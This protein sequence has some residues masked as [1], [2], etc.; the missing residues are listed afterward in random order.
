MFIVALAFACLLMLDPFGIETASALRSE[1]A[2]LRITAP[3]YAGTD[4]VA[5]VL[6]DDAFLK[7]IGRSWPLGYAEQGR[8]LRNVMQAQPAGVFVDLL[9][10][11]AHGEAPA[12][13]AAGGE[14][15]TVRP[16]DDP[17]DLVRP[18]ERF[19][20]TP[21]VLAAQV[22]RD[23]N[24]DVTP[25]LCPE[26]PA[27]EREQLLDDESILPPLKQWV[28]QQPAARSIALVGWWGCGDRYPLILAGR[29]DGMSPAFALLRA[30]CASAP[31]GRAEC[32]GLA[33]ETGVV[34][35]FLRP[36]VVRWGA[37]P[38][39]A[40]RPFYAAGVCQEY[41]AADGSVP[42]ARR[43]WM[44]LEQLLLGVFE[45]LRNSDKPDL[46]L[47]CPSVN[48]IPAS[49]MW[50]GDA[51]AVR[52]LLAGRF[53]MVGAA[54]SGISDWHQSAVHGQ[55]P[56]VVLHAM[57]LDNL[58][59]LGTSYATEMSGRAS[60]RWPS[61][62]LLLLAYVVPRILL[63]HRERNSRAVAA[64]GL[65]GWIALAA[66]LAWSGAS[67]PAVFAAVAVG[68]ALDLIAPM[69]TFSYVLAIGLMGIGAST[70]LRFGVA[71]AN[72]VGMILVAFTFFHA[73][74]QF[75]KD[76]ERKGFP[77]RPL[78]WARRCALGSGDWSFTGFTG[79]IAKRSQP[80]SRRRSRRP[81]H[82]EMPH[83]QNMD[84]PVDRGT[85]GTRV[86]GLQREAREDRGARRH[87]R[88]LR[89]ERRSLSELPKTALD[90]GKAYLV[91][92]RRQA[93]GAAAKGLSR[94]PKTTGYIERHDRYE[95]QNRDRVEQHPGARHVLHPDLP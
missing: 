65:A 77:T 51:P 40:Q 76:E 94:Q 41:A 86:G 39:A 45:D 31:A 53:V 85:R 22:R 34:A 68:I 89:Q 78:S 20:A 81:R 35:N 43:L 52:D 7:R 64:L 5:V 1:Q 59:A 36:M 67:G 62:L 29:A 13:D 10:R 63:R 73:S 70:L 6:I 57:A 56:G 54:V 88:D 75:F 72:W 92:H 90:P 9:Y 71:P 74:K 44:S 47:P 27:R 15:A 48:V 14:T 61:L 84:D 26:Q 82:R 50:S 18:L 91:G 19:A 28:E 58:L 12:P 4:R 2:A 49:V 21:L 46:A 69:Q 95:E 23:L 42:R 16:V 83:E 33:D 11:Q 55:V 3:M 93:R 32:A 87:R 37:Y 8:L 60:S 30:W 38:P 80:Q 66:F 79:I 24:P 17:A 25:A